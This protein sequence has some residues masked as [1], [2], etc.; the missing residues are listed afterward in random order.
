MSINRANM[1]QEL[2]EIKSKIT[3]IKED[4]RTVECFLST[5]LFLKLNLVDRLR[6]IGFRQ[7]YRFL[8]L[9]SLDD[10]IH[11]CNAF[12]GGSNDHAKELQLTKRQFVQTLQFFDNSANDES[13]DTLEPD[14]DLAMDISNNQE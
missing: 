4:M 1:Q 9:R 8:L 5:A 3:M 12:L 11:K 2:A 7:S 14:S 6:R 10:T 13:M